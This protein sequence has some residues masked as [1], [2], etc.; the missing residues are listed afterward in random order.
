MHPVAKDF[1]K[2]VLKSLKTKGIEIYGSTFV[3]DS[4]GNF[5]N[6][7]RAYLLDDKGTSRVRLYLEVLEMAGC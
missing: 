5:C 6:G 7:E 2:Q 1:S 3:P 4:N